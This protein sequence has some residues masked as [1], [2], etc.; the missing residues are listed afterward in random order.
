MRDR[1]SSVVRGDPA[2]VTSGHGSAAGA[3]ADG[4][5]R[6]RGVAAAAGVV[7][8][9][10]AATTRS[11]A[12]SSRAISRVPDIVSTGI[13]TPSAR[14]AG[15]FN[16]VAYLDPIVAPPINLSTINGTGSVVPANGALSAGS[17]AGFRIV[18]RLGGRMSFVG[19]P[20]PGTVA[21]ARTTRDDAAHN[22]GAAA[23]NSINGVAPARCTPSGGSMFPL[24]PTTLACMSADAH[25]NP[26]AV[27]FAGMAADMAPPVVPVPAQATI[28]ATSAAGG[29]LT[30]TASAVDSTGEPVPATCT[31]AI[32]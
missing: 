18:T 12:E 26:A 30:Y 1:A 28:E 8:L 22:L 6:V 29:P 21:I 16:Q 25:G 4:I 24:A 10:L 23:L 31:P 32:A 27:S 11:S 17:P 19:G 9:V 7:I 13:R 5:R 2:P 20:V 15:D 14:L 3:R